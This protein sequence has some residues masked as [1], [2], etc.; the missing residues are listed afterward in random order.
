MEDAEKLVVHFLVVTK[1]GDTAED[2]LSQVKKSSF[3]HDMFGDVDELEPN[4]VSANIGSVTTPESR[5]QSL[6]FS[7]RGTSDIS[8]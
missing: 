8:I 2:E 6:K 7:A 4:E 5:R 3:N 1:F